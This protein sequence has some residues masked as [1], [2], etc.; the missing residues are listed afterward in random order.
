MPE[1]EG[2]R[3]TPFSTVRPTVRRPTVD[4][5]SVSV[6]DLS[7][8]DRANAALRVA[9]DRSHG[10]N[11]HS[12]I[13]S[14][15]DGGDTAR[16]RFVAAPCVHGRDALKLIFEFPSGTTEDQIHAKISMFVAAFPEPWLERRKVYVL[17]ADELRR[18]L[19]AVSGLSWLT[20]RIVMWPE[21]PEELDGTVVL[22]M[23]A[24]ERGPGVL[25]AYD[26]FDVLMSMPDTLLFRRYPNDPWA[27]WVRRPDAGEGNGL[28]GH[29]DLAE[30]LALVRSGYLRT[31]A[32]NLEDG[33]PV[34]AFLLTPKGE[35]LIAQRD[36]RNLTYGEKVYVVTHAHGTEVQA[37]LY[38][39]EEP[40]DA[41]AVLGDVYH[42]GDPYEVSPPIDPKYFPPEAL[43]ISPRDLPPSPFDAS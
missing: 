36:G 39:G 4:S 20:G 29:P 14:F 40:P 31:E 3:E 25:D 26:M 5:S 22:T 38:A 11:E 23:T 30:I 1:H 37:Y 21:A 34:L 41:R 12:L 27:W 28:I 9:K 8:T 42:E 35:R 6:A 18:A 16:V 15:R 32:R 33:S 7:D 24:H 17:L 43:L 19:P 13:I 2:A 10:F